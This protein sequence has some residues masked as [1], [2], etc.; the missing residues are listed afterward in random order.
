MKYYNLLR[1]SREHFERFSNAKKKTLSSLIF[2]NGA[3]WMLERMNELDGGTRIFNVSTSFEGYGYLKYGIC[4]F[5][6]ILSGVFLSNKT[7][8]LLPFAIL[9]FYIL[10]VHFLFLFPLLIDRMERPLLESIRMTYKVGVFR[11]L[12]TVIPIGF[13]YAYGLV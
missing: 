12:F 3:E 1:E 11:T 10:E 4:L 5:S 13:F 8:F 9:V 2:T 7:I 6:F